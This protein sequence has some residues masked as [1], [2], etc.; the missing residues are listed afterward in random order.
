[1]HAVVWDEGRITDL[2][3]LGGYLSIAQAINNRGQVVGL[4]LNDI[5]D[6]VSAFGLYVGTQMRAFLWQ[7]GVMQDLGTLGGPDAWAAL[8]NERGQV[9]GISFTN[10]VRLHPITGVSNHRSV[11]SGKTEGC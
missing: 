8:L 11:L 3:T 9:A 10:S 6:P 5:P 2:G 4:A 1:M 7:N